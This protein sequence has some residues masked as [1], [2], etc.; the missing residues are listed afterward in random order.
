MPRPSLL[1][2][3]ALL[4]ASLVM[5]RFLGSN[6]LENFVVAAFAASASVALGCLFSEDWR[7][8]MLAQLNQT[9]VFLGNL[10]NRA[11]SSPPVNT[12]PQK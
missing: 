4:V 3:G 9:R 12:N 5:A 11:K 6:I 8:L 1:P 2:P 7:A 10:S